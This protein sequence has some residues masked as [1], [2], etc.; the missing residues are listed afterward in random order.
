MYQYDSPETD[1]LGT[2]S[3]IQQRMTADCLSQAVRIS[4]QVVRHVIR[5]LGNN[6]LL[7][8]VC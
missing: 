7:E 2:E 5:E 4:S 3:T 1:S 6:S 8:I